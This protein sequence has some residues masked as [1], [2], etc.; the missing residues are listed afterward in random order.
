MALK[1]QQQA[2]KEE[3]QRIKNLVLNLDLREAEDTDGNSNSKTPVL[4]GTHIHLPSAAGH[5]KTPVYH[6]N[7]SDKMGKDRGGQRVRR[8]QMN[9]LDWYEKPQQKTR[10]WN[11]E[12]EADLSVPEETRAESSKP[13]RLQGASKRPMSLANSQ[14]PSRN[15]ANQT[16]RW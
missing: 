12:P 13:P 9:D 6:L 7:R 3:Q 5:E 15:Q 10:R 14:R 16:R 4:Y 2:E 11:E 8:L 1:N